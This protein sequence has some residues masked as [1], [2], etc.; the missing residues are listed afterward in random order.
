MMRLNIYALTHQFVILVGL[1]CG[2][3]ID[4]GMRTGGMDYWALD[5]MFFRPVWGPVS[6]FGLSCLIAF[7]LERYVRPLSRRGSL[8]TGF[9]GYAVLALFVA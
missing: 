8:M 2:G 7:A 9:C 4:I 6:L 5:L 1:I 3:V